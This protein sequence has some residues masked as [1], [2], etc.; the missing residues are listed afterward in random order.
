[1][2]EEDADIGLARQQLER[3]EVSF[4]DGARRYEDVILELDE[5]ETAPPGL[6][7]TAR[8]EF[9]LY[10]AGKGIQA[11]ALGLIAA[12]SLTR[13]GRDLEHLWNNAP[14]NLRHSEHA[15][16][17]LLALFLTGRA[18]AD[19]GALICCGPARF[20]DHLQGL[21][22]LRIDADTF[23]G[24]FAIDFLLTYSE[25]GPNPAHR[26][27][28]DLPVGKTVEHRVAMVRDETSAGDYGERKLRRQALSRSF[29][30]TVVSYCDDD[31]RRDVFGLAHRTIVN[32]AQHV[33]DGFDEFDPET[34]ST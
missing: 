3:L 34:R 22:N 20:G 9:G 33:S 12:Q 26:A 16:A 30:V 13:A 21:E 29:G 8:A 10:Y 14:G 11:T 23:L 1:M 27:K 6:D 17:L 19:G 24:D 5:G 31:V 18:L 15:A 25:I 2:S 28:P 4:A 32:L 7:A